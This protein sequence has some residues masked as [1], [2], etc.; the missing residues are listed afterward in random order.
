VG[1]ALQEGGSSTLE[2]LDIQTSRG[3][4]I[5]ALE[6]ITP[7]P[8]RGRGNRAGDP[9]RGYLLLPQGEVAQTSSLAGA[10]VL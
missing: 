3:A 1:I 8:A 9:A 6:T 4:M 5:K 2:T 7:S 10:P